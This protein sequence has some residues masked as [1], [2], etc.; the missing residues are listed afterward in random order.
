MD[1]PH[2][3][4]RLRLRPVTPE[5]APFILELLTSKS[6]LE[7]IGDRGVHTLDDARGYITEKLLPAYNTPG[8]GP[9]LC[10]LKSDG[11]IIG[12]TGVYRR[13]GLDTPDFGFAFLEAY[14]GQGFAHEASISNMA[15]AVA[16]GHKELL[17]ITLPTNEPSLSLLSK[18]GFERERELIQLP[19]DDEE[20]VLLRWEV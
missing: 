8:C 6:W 4:Q 1:I 2:P 14:H 10:T 20:L 3:T 15:Y 5:D 9:M 17:A 16:H 7:N 12:N 19:G 11:T 18:L 13:P